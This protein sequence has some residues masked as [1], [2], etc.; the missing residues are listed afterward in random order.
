MRDLKL[1]KRQT[2][3]LLLSRRSPRGKS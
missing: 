3:F 1:L 2:D